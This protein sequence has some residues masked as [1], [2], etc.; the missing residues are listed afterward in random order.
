LRLGIGRIWRVRKVALW[1]DVAR[2][3]HLEAGNFDRHELK[4]IEFEPV[5]V[6]GLDSRPETRSPTGSIPI[7]I[8]NVSRS[9]DFAASAGSFIKLSDRVMATVLPSAGLPLPTSSTGIDAPCL[10]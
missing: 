10:S 2:S 4:Q 6:N 7:E 3:N 8:F 9:T 1:I 5:E